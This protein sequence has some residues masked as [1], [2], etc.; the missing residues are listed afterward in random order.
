MDVRMKITLKIW[1]AFLL[2]WTVLAEQLPAQ[3]AVVVSKKNILENL[4]SANLRL[5]Y[6]GKKLT[7][8]NGLKITLAERENEKKDFYS[9]LLDYS[10]LKVKKHWIRSVMAGKRAVPPV[11]LSRVDQVSS[12]LIEHPGGICFIDFE[13]VT[14]DMKV[15]T[16]NSKKPDE[17][18]YSLSGKQ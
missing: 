13:L 2:F 7:F 4:S 16:I 10:I 8:S 15:L 17:S 1:I 18:G 3:I 11:E 12:F 9:Q 5:I 14:N 6:L